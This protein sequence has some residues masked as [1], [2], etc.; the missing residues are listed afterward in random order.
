MLLHTR[1]L[2]LLFLAILTL[3]SWA[4]VQAISTDRPDQSDGVYTLPKR[5][6]QLESGITIAKNTALSNTMLRYGL[7]QGTEFRVAIDA[8]TTTG[9]KGLLPLN[10][11]IK[12]KINAAQGL[13]P[14]TALLAD[15]TL[16]PLAS[17]NFSQN[18]LDYGLKLSFEHEISDALSFCYN[19][20]GSNSLNILN[21][22]GSLAFAS[23]AKTSWFA[24]YFAELNT[25]QKEH[26]IDIGWTTALARGLQMDF[27][28]G[29]AIFDH[30]KRLFTTIGLSYC[31]DDKP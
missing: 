6:F 29:H 9:I 1:F 10:L 27:A 30:D 28:I 17:R 16:G 15:V 7:L 26:N 31:F 21:L 24:E 12:Q 22:S 25:L 3:P 11:S 2:C 19:V 20:G 4:Q 8:G 5:S 13:L 23:S 18:K 14:A